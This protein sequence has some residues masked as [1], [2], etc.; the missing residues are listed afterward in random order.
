MATTR[1]ARNGK[2]KK[3]PP[4]TEQ[5]DAHEGTPDSSANDT[6][7]VRKPPVYKVGP[8]PTRKGESVQGCVWEHD[9]TTPDGKTYKTHQVEVRASYFSEKDG[10][11]YD[12]S[13]F[14]PSQLSALE[15]VLRKCGD[16]CFNARDAQLK[17]RED[18]PEE[19][20]PI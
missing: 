2:P 20:I 19:E 12:S 11:W 17:P 14:K 16:Y 10:A 15:Y 13:G 7:T 8:I 4:E 1:V 5:G 18:K 3:P 9:F 6:G